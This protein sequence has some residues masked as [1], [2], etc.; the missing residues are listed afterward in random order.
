[1]KERVEV[2][3]ISRQIDEVAKTQTLIKNV[4]T[5][6]VS[7]ITDKNKIVKQFL[8]DRESQTT[9]EI[10]KRIC[11]EKKKTL[12]SGVR[13]T[14]ANLLAYLSRRYKATVARIIV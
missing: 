3:T 1:M 5:K 7:Q 9:E 14:K 10:F 2:A 11:K 4:K 6:K 12:L 8:I 13:L